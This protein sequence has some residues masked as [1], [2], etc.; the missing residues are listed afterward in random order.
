MNNDNMSITGV[1]HSLLDECCYYNFYENARHHNILKNFG[2]FFSNAQY[3]PPFP[4]AS[5]DDSKLSNAD[6]EL[7]FYT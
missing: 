1:V 7:G 4:G 6:S 2:A 5:M 3:N